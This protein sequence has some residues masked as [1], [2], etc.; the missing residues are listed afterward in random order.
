MLVSTPEIRNIRFFALVLAKPE[1]PGPQLRAH[2]AGNDCSGSPT[3]TR[4][5]TVFENPPEGA[6]LTKPE[7]LVGVFPTFCGGVVAG[8]P[9]DPENAPGLFMAGGR[10]MSMDLIADFFSMRGPRNNLDRLILDRTGLAGKY[11]FI[12]EWSSPALSNA[13]P[14]T[15]GAEYADCS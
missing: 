1:K 3:I 5:G 4:M 6:R 7:T 15:M 10:G 8:L 14:L 11:D 12:V 2:S 9:V 13:A